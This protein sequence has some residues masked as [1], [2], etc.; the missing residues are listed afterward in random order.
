RAYNTR[1][2][3][4]EFIRQVLALPF[5]PPEHK[6]ETFHHL[7][8]H[9]QTDLLDSLMEYVWRQWLNNPTFPVRNWSVFMLSIRT[10]NDVEG[11]HN[12]LNSRV[13]QRGPVP[14]YLLLVELHKEAKQ[15]PLQAKLISEGKMVRIHKK[16]TTHVNGKLFAAWKQYSEGEMTTSQLLRRCANVYGPSD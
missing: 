3:V 11:W 10:N 14:F 5:L 7:D 8:R 9:V 13:A 4:H 2:E 1:G 15:I 6:V 12:R 16:R